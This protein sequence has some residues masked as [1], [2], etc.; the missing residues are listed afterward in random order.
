MGVEGYD[1]P[2]DPRVRECERC[3]GT[4]YVYT[5]GRMTE[6]GELT[7]V[8]E[9]D[10]RTYRKCPEDWEAETGEWTR[11]DVDRCPR[12]DGDGWID[13]DAER[14]EE[15][16]IARCERYEAEREERGIREYLE[17]HNL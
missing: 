1:Y 13:E 9:V 16:E 14:E 6:S 11:D 10:E 15:E 5:I 3:H 8:R 2:R 12:C 4:G 17:T 7:D